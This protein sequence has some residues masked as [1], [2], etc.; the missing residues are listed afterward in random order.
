M[1]KPSPAMIVALLALFVAL[2]GA[3]IAATGGNFILGQ[4]NMADQTTDLQGNVAN[5]QFRVTNS[6][7]SGIAIRGRHSAATGAQPAVQGDTASTSAGATGVYGL[8]SSASSAG[9]SNGVKGV[10]SGAGRGVYGQGASGPGVY[11]NST[12]GYGVWGIGTYGVVAGGSQGGV[13]ASTDN[14]S[15]G[16]VYGQNTSGVTAEGAG[17]FGSHSSTA[18]TGSG[19]RGET[20]SGSQNATGILARAN[21]TNPGRDAVAL[22]AINKSTNQYGMGVWASIAG[23]G[24]GVLGEAGDNGIGVI[25]KLPGAGTGVYG[26]TGSGGVGVRGVGG[27]TGVYGQA[28]DSTGFAFAA[29]G[30]AGQSRTGGGWVKAMAL[31]NPNQPAGQQVVRCYNSQVAPGTP[32]CGITATGWYVGDWGIDFG[33]DISDRFLLVTAFY[34]GRGDWRG[35]V[36]NAQPYTANVAEV[37][38][39]YNGGESTNSLFYIY[40][41]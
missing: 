22:R 32:S 2:G 23:S 31:I 40:V 26:L 29:N 7:P 37:D 27:K 1:H 3:G 28:T 34:A 11:G 17:V 33:F 39:A 41:F 4:Q 13:W 16:G 21:A 14:G 9:D 6:N 36:A 8:N 25:G 18:G 20:N 35:I 5:P 38:L 10:N 19:V 30:N 12:S 15:G 24:W